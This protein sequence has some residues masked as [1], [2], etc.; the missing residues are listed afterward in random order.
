MATVRMDGAV[1]STAHSGPVDLS[2]V[3]PEVG[4]SVKSVRQ[5][6][7]DCYEDIRTF[8]QQEPDEVMRLVSGH[9][10]RMSELRVRCQRIED[11][12]RIWKQVRTREIEPTMEELTQQY[13]IA[14]RLHSVRDLDFRMSGGQP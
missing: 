4:G 5:E 9:S 14:S 8:Y 13:N 12:H 11:F 6:I 7:D 1:V 3:Y 2:R 10:A